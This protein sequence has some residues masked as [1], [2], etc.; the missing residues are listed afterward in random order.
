MAT[1]MNM[2]I[3]DL[4][5]ILK[6]L[7]IVKIIRRIGFTINYRSYGFISF[8]VAF[9]INESLIPRF[10]ERLMNIQSVKHNYLRDH[11]RY[12]VWFTIRCESDDEI[13]STIKQLASDFN[14]YDYIVLKSIKTCK[15]SVKY[16]LDK[17]IS[18]STPGK[19]YIGTKE[20]DEYGLTPEVLRDLRNIP[21]E[22]RPYRKI[23]MKYGFGEEEFIDIL[24]ELDKDG[25]IQDYGGMLSGE[26]IGFIHNCMV[27]FKGNENLCRKL[28]ENAYEATHIV[29]RK[30]LYGIWDGNIYFMI[31]GTDK[32]LLEKHIG[33]IMSQIGIDNY[34]KIYSIKKLKE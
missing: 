5:S 26:E 12:N 31:H 33:K 30:T 9:N 6:H 23:A 4:I 21:I 3:E 34:L 15:L 22:V 28:L 16:D 25:L 11:R 29:F 27:V 8:L 24:R 32:T 17:G 1:E 10:R 20:L 2:N 14:V 7:Y 19:T 13:L 18:W